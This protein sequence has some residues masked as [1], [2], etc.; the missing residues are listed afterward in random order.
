MLP[1]K[2]D[3]SKKSAA[4]ATLKKSLSEAFDSKCAI[5]ALCTIEFLLMGEMG[6][7]EDEPGQIADL[8]EA[9]DRLK[10]FVA[11]EI[12]ENAGGDVDKSA[13]AGPL[14]K[15]GARHSAADKGNLAKAA[16]S[17]D[18]AS[19]HL[20][21][22][23]KHHGKVGEAHDGMRKCMGAMHDCMKSVKPGDLSKMDAEALAKFR[24]DMEDADG[25]MSDHMDEME[26]HM[27]KADKHHAKLGKAHDG[28]EAAH[29]AAHHALKA[30]GAMDAPADDTAEK[31]AHA[32]MKKAADELTLA[33]ADL[34]ATQNE[35]AELKK[36]L[37]TINGQVPSLV[38]RIKKLEAQPMPAKGAVFP[39][40]KGHEAKPAETPVEAPSYSTFGAS[41]EQQRAL[42]GIH[43]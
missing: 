40:T 2:W 32:E 36:A 35:N 16:A 33:K 38:E 13:A 6:E 30:V 3:E 42:L 39:V 26:T 8:K 20:E 37:D 29:D 28:I 14:Q 18:E 17:V 41:P 24:K 15:A 31:A 27:D 21:D 22:A 25:K 7:E 9:I 12:M 5:E 19:D 34:T 43:N 4:I 10:S 23:K 11:S 1:E